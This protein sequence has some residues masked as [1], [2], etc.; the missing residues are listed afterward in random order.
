MTQTS[1]APVVPEVDATAAGRSRISGGWLVLVN[2]GLILLASAVIVGWRGGR[3]RPRPGRRSAHQLRVQGWGT[4][5]HS[6]SRTITVETSENMQ[7]TFTVQVENQSDR[8]VTL[9]DVRA[10]LMGPDTG[11]VIKGGDHRRR[12]ASWR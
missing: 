9:G 10:V 12:H 11:S 7:C 2:I 1:T 4:R 3:E 8:D 5:V 6:K